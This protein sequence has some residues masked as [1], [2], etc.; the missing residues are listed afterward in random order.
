MSAVGSPP[1]P[2]SVVAA[3]RAFL[4]AVTAAVAKYGEPDLVTLDDPDDN[5]TEGLHANTVIIPHAF[6]T[7]VFYPTLDGVCFC[8]YPSERWCP[9][10]DQHICTTCTPKSFYR[11]RPAPPADSDNSEVH[12]CYSLECVDCDL[13]WTPTTNVYDLLESYGSRNNDQLVDLPDEDIHTIPGGPSV[14]DCAE[15]IR[16]IPRALSAI[17]Q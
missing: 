5:D 7:L 2:P 13:E 6:K 3:A 14:A 9:T 11:T 4:A 1:P 16:I 10:C 17:N 15:A 8:D 12:N